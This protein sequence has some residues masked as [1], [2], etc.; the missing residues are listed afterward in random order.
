VPPQTPDLKVSPQ[1]RQIDL[2]S[3]AIL[4]ALDES[5]SVSGAARASGLTQPQVTVALS[6]L[7]TILND[8]L[9]VRTPEGMEPTP[10][11][12]ALVKSARHA[13]AQIDHAI[14]SNDDEFDPT[15]TRQPFTLA[16]TDA[17]EM[18]FL[19]RLVRAL[20]EAAP[21]AQVRSVGQT[22][23]D[24]AEGLEDGSIDLAIG[25]QPE[26]RT[27]HF[28]HQS[29]FTD[30]FMCL[31]RADHPATRR[32]PTLEEFAK[33]DHAVVQSVVH[34]QGALERYLAGNNL[35]RRVVVTIQ[36]V[37]GM[38]MLLEQSDMLVVAPQLICNYF[39]NV[40]A[41]LGSVVLPFE[42]PPLELRQHWHRKY[43]NE[44]RN[45][46]LRALVASTF[47]DSEKPVLAF[48]PK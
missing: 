2:N 1:A 42:L 16:M 43:Q 12:C 38:P 26:L 9:F 13:L 21:L 6:K 19:P 8:R 35:E 48:R 11:A 29:L 40:S 44:P 20:R 47:Q 18:V 39:L 14:L 5:R 22:S 4:V 31:A 15:T 32:A 23:G 34:S 17:G 28:F 45:R 33:Y 46:W 30:S 41:D 37:S 27:N 24:I 25:Y 3:L 36:H 7:R 10:R